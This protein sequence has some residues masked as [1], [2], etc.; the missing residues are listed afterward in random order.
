MGH[1]MYGPPATE[2]NF[3]TNVTRGCPRDITPSTLPFLVD[4][5]RGLFDSEDMDESCIKLR[6]LDESLGLIYLLG[7][8]LENIVLLRS[9]RFGYGF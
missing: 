4:A 5:T 2:P 1:P 8:S 7:A 9:S 6:P 3:L